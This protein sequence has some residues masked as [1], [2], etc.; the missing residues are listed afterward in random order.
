LA[1]IA[2]A[3]RINITDICRL[4]GDGYLDLDLL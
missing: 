2:P 3:A 4:E 1:I